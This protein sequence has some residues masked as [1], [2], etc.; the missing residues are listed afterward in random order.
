LLSAYIDESER[1]EEYYFL[2]AGICD[3]SQQEYIEHQIT[4]LLTKHS[5]TF[6]TL[7]A[8][9]ELHGN[10][11]LA[12]RKQWKKV[13]IR[14]RFGIFTEALSIVEQSGIC[15]HIEGI[16]ITRLQERYRYPTP[17]RELALSHLLERINE[18]AF[19]RSRSSVTVY[20]DEHHTKETSR[21]NFQKYQ[22]FGTYG[23]K[24]SKLQQIKDN[25]E[26]IDSRS[27]RVMQGVDLVTYLHNRRTTI[28][29]RDERAERQKRKMWWIIS[30]AVRRGNMRT[31]P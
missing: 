10:E 29:E 27:S 22:I 3:K 14:A 6:P 11:I 7:S 19:K 1:N 12:G 21:S 23:Y 15:I 18:C 9:Q 17:A 26:F 24:S 2:G 28:Q 5:A 8:S 30:P 20:A 25:I 13:P 4:A 16:D 31:W